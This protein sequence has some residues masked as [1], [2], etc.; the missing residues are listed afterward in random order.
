M[1]QLCLLLLT[2]WT[3][4]A[5]RPLPEPTQFF[6]EVRKTLRSDR[7]LFSQ[8]T[9]TQ[10]E[11]HITLDSNGKAKKTDVSIYQVFHRAGS[12]VPYRR[13]I[14]KNGVAVSE[15]ELAKRDREEEQR[16]AREHKKDDPNTDSANRRDKG[17]E[18][19][20]QEALDD[21]FAM[22]D[23][24][25]LQREIIAGMPTIAVTFTPKLNYK[26]KTRD[27]K[28]LQHIS[29][30]AWISEEDHQLAKLEAQVNDP[31]SIGAGILAKLQKGST[32]MFERRKINNEI[33]L[34]VKADVTLNARLLLFKGLNFREIDEYS[35]HKKY[36]VDTI[37][38]FGDVP[39]KRPQ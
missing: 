33:W 34:P 29:G 17:R 37:L 2:L 20:E 4:D 36:T 12:G 39:Q 9:Y 24:K 18:D 15:E 19:R 30:R 31:I 35:D 3:Q 22:Y 26:P 27:G 5:L 11:T 14:S 1:I 28:I 23:I 13:L 8:Y 21:V 6:A 16:Q 32:L 38:K 25:M 7:A 10:A